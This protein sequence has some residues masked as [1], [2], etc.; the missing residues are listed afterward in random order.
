MAERLVLLLGIPTDDIRQALTA[1]G[2][3]VTER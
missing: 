3:I 2:G 1:A